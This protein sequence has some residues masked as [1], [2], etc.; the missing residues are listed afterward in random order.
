MVFK[1]DFHIVKAAFVVAFVSIGGWLTFR[2]LVEIFNLNQLSPI[3]RLIIGIG[4]IW[5]SFRLGWKKE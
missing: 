3:W 4:I 5:L 2:A 1:S